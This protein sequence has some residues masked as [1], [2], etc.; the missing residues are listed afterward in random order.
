MSLHCP[1]PEVQSLGLCLAVCQV[2]LRDLTVCGWKIEVFVCAM[3][4]VKNFCLSEL[5]VLN[6]CGLCV[7]FACV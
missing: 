6:D 3:F 5:V 1:L 4:C 2:F 7:L